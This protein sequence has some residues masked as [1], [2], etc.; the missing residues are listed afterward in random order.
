MCWKR[1]PLWHTQDWTT[2]R[3][4]S[5][6]HVTL[7]MCIVSSNMCM[8]H[9]FEN[10]SFQSLQYDSLFIHEE[11]LGLDVKPRQHNASWMKL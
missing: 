2:I 6:S 4:A 11:E 7:E 8:S 3:I 1:Y 10:V 9:S 5:P